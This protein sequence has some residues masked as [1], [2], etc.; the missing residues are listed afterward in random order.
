MILT[1]LIEL[2]FALTKMIENIIFVALCLAENIFGVTIFHFILMKS[3]YLYFIWVFSFLL[4]TRWVNLLLKL[5]F[6]WSRVRKWLCVRIILI[7]LSKS[8][9]FG[10]IAKLEAIFVRFAV[11]VS[12]FCWIF[13]IAEIDASC[14][15]WWL[16]LS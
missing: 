8:S 3:S 10:L 7:L 1:F 16:S 2:I 6:Y 11:L 14:I 5:Y 9:I 15:M 4:E 13:Y 12:T